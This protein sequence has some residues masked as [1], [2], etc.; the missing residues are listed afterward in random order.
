MTAFSSGLKVLMMSVQE[1]EE[2]KNRGQ[3]GEKCTK[4]VKECRD[5]KGAAGGV[6]TRG[7]NGGHKSSPVGVSFYWHVR[8]LELKIS[9][10]EVRSGD[11]VVQTTQLSSVKK[12][13]RV[14]AL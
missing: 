4:R 9:R 12:P 2:G 6:I 7:G 11:I 13:F 14:S 1:T 10:D 3:G 5:K 8:I